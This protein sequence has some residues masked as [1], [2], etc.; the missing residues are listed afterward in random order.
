VKPRGAELTESIAHRVLQLERALGVDSG[1]WRLSE[2]AGD[3]LEACERRPLPPLMLQ[4]LDAVPCRL[5]HRF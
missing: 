2:G 4:N 1:R 3:V 5:T